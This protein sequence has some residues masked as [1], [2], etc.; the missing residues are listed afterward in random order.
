MDIDQTKKDDK[1]LDDL[2]AKVNNF[3]AAF[4]ENVKKVDGNFDII[5]ERFSKLENKR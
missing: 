1:K 4:E 2:I 3:K 5:W